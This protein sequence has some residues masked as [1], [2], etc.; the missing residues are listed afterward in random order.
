MR[1]ISGTARGTRLVNLGSADIRPTL[2][3]VKE[4][5]F[6]QVGPALEG[7][8]FLDLFAGSGSIGIEA[9]SRGAEKVVFV[10]PNLKAQRIIMQNLEKCRM[11]GDSPRW[12][13]LKSSALAG[14]KTLKERNLSFDLV[15][16]DP[17]FD[18]DLYEPTL[19]GLSPSEILRQDAIIVAEHFHK[20]V[21]KT[22]YD[23]LDFHKD[24]RLGDT[25]ISFFS[26]NDSL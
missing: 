20:T 3:R 2:D 21:L 6:N 9:L 18:D 10:E 8:T 26:F 19:L 17:P 14:L 24:R 11:T 4:S 16:V 22:N 7:L 13:L 5:F 25:C 23:K 15:Y 1:I 12:I